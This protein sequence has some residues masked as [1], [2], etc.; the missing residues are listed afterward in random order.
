MSTQVTWYG[1][2]YKTHVW[3]ASELQI[4]R[5]MYPDHSCKEI[6]EAINAA[7][8]HPVKVTDQG[9][10]YQARTMRLK[11]SPSFKR[12]H[13][14]IVSGQYGH[15]RTTE[16]TRK[17]GVPYRTSKPDK[18]G[19]HWHV[20]DPATGRRRNAHRWIVEQRQG[21]LKPT[22]V[23]IFEDGDRTR[24]DRLKVV[25]RGSVQHMAAARWATEQAE[26]RHKAWKTRRA[27]QATESYKAHRPYSFAPCQ[28]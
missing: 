10:L 18:D 9:V 13:A 4:V 3:T 11:K 22:D 1:K 25:S 24:L 20:I 16:R 7:T 2:P 12:S 28:S 21:P 15:G 17:P 27:K 14:S 8:E 26:A 19:Y 23:V 6:A 5:R